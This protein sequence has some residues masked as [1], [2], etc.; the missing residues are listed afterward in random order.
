MIQRRYDD[1]GN[2]VVG[3]ESQ[4]FHHFQ[5]AFYEV[6]QLEY[7][8]SFQSRLAAFRQRLFFVVGGDDPIVSPKAVIESGPAGGI[9]VLEIGGMGHFLGGAAKDGEEKSSASSGSLRLVGLFTNF[10]TRRPR[11]IPKT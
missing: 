1:R 11:Y 4:L 6:F 8:G 5:R 10:P 7:H 9:N 2:G 3:L